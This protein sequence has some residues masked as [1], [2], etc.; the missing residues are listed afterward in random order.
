MTKPFRLFFTTRIVALA[1]LVPAVGVAQEKL[2]PTAKPEAV[3]MSSEVLAEIGPTMQALIDRAATGGIMTMVAREGE[4]VHWD[5]Y[6]WRER[7]EDPLALDDIFRIYSMTKPVTSVAAMM[8]VEDGLLSLDDDLGDILPEFAGVKV[9]GDGAT[10]APERPISVRDLF[11]HT[12]GLTYGIFGDS[13]VDSMY[14]R[15][16]SA[17]SRESGRN[18]AETVEAIGSLPL[19]DDP[20]ARWNYSMSTDVLGRV[21]EVAS[22]HSLDE[23][24]RSRIF[25]PL[26]MDDTG[27][28]VS[29]ENLHRLTV[30][31]S[32]TDD[33]LVV[34]SDGS[35]TRPPHWY[36]GGGGLTS[37]AADYLR[38]CRMLLGG[39]ELD[40]VRLLKAET[41]REMTTNQ[42]PEDLAPI[43][44]WPS[45]QGFGLGFSVTL[46]VEE[47]TYLWSGVANTYF[48]VDPAEDLIVMAWTQLQPFGAA[49]LNR[50]IRPIVYRAIMDSTER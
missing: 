33:G 35:F 39:G 30:V 19:I 40:G 50:I 9:Y 43:S 15:A 17:L 13:P 14:N 7:D 49:P 23:F 36:S 34:G 44:E 16:L 31:Y 4:I 29:A 5:A 27:F 10:R 20:G 28:H 25:E 26:G 22:G 45:E 12:S 48:W 1:T 42:L 41:V 24:F 47:P 21:V 2:G 32:R 37:T 6:G 11:L 38:F 46:G 18:L 3:G 8:L